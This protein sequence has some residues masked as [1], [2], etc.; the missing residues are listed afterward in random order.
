MTNSTLMFF[1]PLVLT[2]R[3]RVL[4]GSLAFVVTAGDAGGGGDFRLESRFDAL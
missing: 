4:F 1:G 3:A 2:E